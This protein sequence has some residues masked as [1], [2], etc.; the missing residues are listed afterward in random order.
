MISEQAYIHPSAKIGKDVT[1]GPFCYVGADV[2]LGD[3]CVLEPSVVVKGP[4]VIGKN[5]HFYQ[6]A[7]IGEDCQDKKYDGEPTRL[8]MG[9]NNVVREHVTI[10]RGTIQ[11]N[12]LTQI[13]SNCLLMAQ[14]H[15]AHDCMV[16][17]NVIMANGASI[18]GHCH[19]GDWAILGGMTGVHQF[20]H[21]GAHA[22]TA[23]YSLVL[24]DV[25]PYVMAAGQSAVPRGI[26][27]EGLK[28]RGFS[29]EAIS[30][31]KRSYRSTFRANLGKDEA[32][33]AMAEDAAQF[34]EVKVF[35]DFLA[36]SSRGVIR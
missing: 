31:I 27:S 25:P 32:I 18:A 5:N 9:D 13:G 20:V 8:V 1:I 28:R 36:N 6:F 34:D 33:E 10:H 4:S 30:A 29:K 3:G 24:Q 19:V 17:D 35:S 26:N 2:E 23:G 14:V 22:F 21:I 11:D 16:G 12:S 15:I 7:S